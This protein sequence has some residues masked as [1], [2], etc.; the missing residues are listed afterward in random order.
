MVMPTV[1]ETENLSLYFSRSVTK[2]QGGTILWDT[3][4]YHVIFL[5]YFSAAYIEEAL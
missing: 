1:K 2:K 5:D 4:S 3:Q